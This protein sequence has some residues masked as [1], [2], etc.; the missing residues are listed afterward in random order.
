MSIKQLP[1]K[2]E[3]KACQIVFSWKDNLE[4]KKLLDVISS[5]LADEYI[6]IAKENKDF[7]GI[8]RN[9]EIAS[10]PLTRSSAITGLSRAPRNDR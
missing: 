3:P 5:I 4:V 2:V 10:S 8:I 9:V 1:E 7:Y 6:Q